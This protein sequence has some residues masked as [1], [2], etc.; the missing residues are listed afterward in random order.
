VA[1]LASGKIIAAECALAVMTSHTTLSASGC[2]MVKRL[3]RRH[4]PALR[5]A[6]PDLMT[7]STG[8]FLMF[9]VTESYTES[10]C[11]FGC[12]AIATQLVACSAG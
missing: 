7:L 3:G 1:P 9:G 11:G 12:A 8:F 2:M 6:G 10:L 5:L 4:L